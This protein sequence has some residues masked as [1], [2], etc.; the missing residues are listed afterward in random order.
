MI[1][2]Q[3][4]EQK[5]Q[6][7]NEH[8]PHRQGVKSHNTLPPATHHPHSVRMHA[9][10]NAICIP[11]LLWEALRRRKAIG[12]TIEVATRWTAA[13]RER[14]HARREA[15][16]STHTWRT[17]TRRRHRTVRWERRRTWRTHHPRGR[18][19]RRKRWTRSRRTTEWRS[20]VTHGR[21]T[22]RHRRR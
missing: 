14:R 6:Y 20:S 4:V 21:S 15:T 11:I 19:S 1:R 22:E 12:R 10:W 18:H 9:T 3:E 2:R 7:G 16:R 13:G 17:H 5:T 8:I